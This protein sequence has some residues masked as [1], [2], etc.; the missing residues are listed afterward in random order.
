MKKLLMFALLV[1]WVVP[2]FAQVDTA[3][4]RRY[5]GPVN[6]WDQARAIAVDGSGN[7]Y[8]TGRSAQDSTY[9]IPYSDYATI[10]Y[11][12]NGDT[13]W[14]RRYNG[15]GN[16]NDWAYAIAVDGSGNVYVTGG[17]VGSVTSSDYATVKYYPN[18]DTAWVRTYNGPGNS[19]DGACD[20]A[21]DGSG[22]VYVTGTSFGSGT[23]RD[24]TTIK[25]VQNTIAIVGTVKDASTQQN[26]NAVLVETLQGDIVKGSDNTN[27]A[28]QYTIPNLAP[29]TYEVRASK[30]GYE[31][32]SVFNQTAIPGGTITVDFQ[33]TPLPTTGTIT[34]NVSEASKGPLSGV[35]V[36]ALQNGTEVARYTTGTDGLYS[37]PN[38]PEGVYD[39][40]VCKENY[41]TQT[42]KGI[43]VQSGMSTTQDYV[44]SKGQI[45]LYDNF[46]DGV[47]DGWNVIEG[48]CNWQIS[49][50]CYSTGSLNG[51]RVWCITSRGDDGWRNYSLD[52][53]VRGNAG[54]DKVVAF[55]V[56]D[57]DNFYAVNLRGLWNGSQEIT[58]NKMSNGLFFADI[59]HV[60]FQNQQNVWY[61][62]RIE[63]LAGRV[64][65]FVN[66]QQKI[67]WQDDGTTYGRVIASGKV[68]LCGW[69]GDAGVN[70]VSF[71][72][73]IVY[74]KGLGGFVVTRDGYSFPNFADPDQY[75]DQEWSDFVD[76][77][78]PE[79]IYAENGDVLKQAY[80]F[81]LANY[82]GDNIGLCGGFSFSSILFFA[83]ELDLSQEAAALGQAQ[84]P[85]SVYEIERTPEV[86]HFL[87]RYH[88]YVRSEEIAEVA[89]LAP[90]GQSVEGFGVLSQNHQMGNPEAYALLLSN[91]GNWNH[92]VVADVPE[93]N[94]ENPDEWFIY[95]YDPRH[96]GEST[97]R[98]IIHASQQ[99]WNYSD[100]INTPDVPDADKTFWWIPYSAFSGPVKPYPLSASELRTYEEIERAIQEFICA[101]FIDP[102]GHLLGC[103][104]EGYKN[105]IPGAVLI[106]Q[107]GNLSDSICLTS[108]SLPANLP[109]TVY[110]HAT[111]SG[112]YSYSHFFNDDLFMIESRMNANGS[113]DQIVYMD[114]LNRLTYNTNDS[115]KHCA[116]TWIKRLPNRKAEHIFKIKNT[117]ISQLDTTIIKVDSALTSIK[118]ANFGA[119][120]VYDL[121][122]ERT[123]YNAGHY[124]FTNLPIH[125]NET[126][127]L[128]PSNWENLDSTEMTVKIDHDNNGTID[129]TLV[130]VNQYYH[131]IC[132]DSDSDGFGDPGHPEN[133]C[134]VDNCPTIYNPYQEDTD[135]DGIGDACEFIRGDANRDG[136]I[137]SAD[138]VYLINYL[139]VGGP[140]PVSWQAGDAN[141]DGKINSADVAYLINYLFIGGPEPGC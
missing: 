76:A 80:Y 43:A 122:L 118:Y 79:D 11:Y 6:Y 90:Q 88:W 14:V 51:N 137:N 84:I 126:H 67:Q 18:G 124:L 26:L 96:P 64:T 73:V 135:G 113:L 93:V 119:P 27:N 78:G 46:D 115:S 31:T 39:L 111:D 95:V 117:S 102:F 47:P 85:A 41:V 34:G 72:N 59:E 29:G 130:V 104:A 24:Y 86:E 125:A 141:C 13:A 99:S 134:L 45:L 108:Y 58:L 98:V 97:N 49:S 114:S 2:C 71:D 33:L 132:F 50:G 23:D 15:P 12:A 21:V 20:I 94:P 30:T 83:K 57:P 61:Y 133:N 62:L 105:E 4:V 112:Q 81:F 136:V 89:S 38:L 54:V 63:I 55:R 75:D 120:K 69:T 44:V 116:F 60:S 107:W 82:L 92:V 52:V 7:V 1:F 109:V 53:W 106:P 139:F 91:K 74:R 56:Q 129:D 138:V 32:Q 121:E 127:I 100:W 35:I 17:S 65:I 128:T 131:Y 37:F 28:G 19:S 42:S 16:G 48:S 87:E 110:M 8:V 123:G 101:E 103:T 3:W 140:A 10:K 40:E 5:N 9:P 25:Y 22:N 66:G 70:D 68:A 77:F 36:C